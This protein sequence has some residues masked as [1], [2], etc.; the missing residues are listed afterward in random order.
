V[1]F[2]FGGP[3]L[4]TPFELNERAERSMGLPA[5]SLPR[6]PFDPTTDAAWTAQQ[7]GRITERDY[8]NAC[9]DAAGLD[10]NTY[11]AHFYE[12]FGDHHVRPEVDAFV[13][14]VQRDGRCAGVLSNDLTV[15]MTP[16]WRASITL[17]RRLSPV[18]DLGEHGV[19]KP[20]PRAYELGI[21]AVGAIPSDIV[22]VDDQPANV[23]AAVD[24]GLV[25][26]WFDITDVADSF[27]RI[28]RAVWD[29]AVRSGAVRNGES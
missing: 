17:L 4:R 5:G 23:A 27:E 18:I 3:V 14:D 15:L 28:R 25:G 11:F 6:G 9:F 22:F 10:M 29:G 12:P 24:A 7:A 13:E 21:E 2:D 26:V 16:Q 1:L 8:W 19:L 20:D